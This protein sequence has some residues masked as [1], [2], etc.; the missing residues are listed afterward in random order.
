MEKRRRGEEEEKVDECT[1][2]G[3]EEEKCTVVDYANCGMCAVDEDL[4]PE[5]IANHGMCA[6]EECTE[7]EPE[8]LT[9]IAECDTVDE[10]TEAGEEVSN[11]GM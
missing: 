10:C 9:R 5:A 7:G 8:S 4:R 1:E 6:V 3:E 11:R 2:G